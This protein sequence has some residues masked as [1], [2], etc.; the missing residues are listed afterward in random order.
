MSIQSY[1]E[2]FLSELDAAFEKEANA[3][4]ND[5]RQCGGKHQQIAGRID[6]LHDAANMAKETYKLFVDTHKDEDEDAPK[7]IY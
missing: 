5:V 1:V 4:L 6:G 7:A 3:L 2:K